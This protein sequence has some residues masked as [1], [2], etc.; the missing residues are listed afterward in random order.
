MI[1]KTLWIVNTESSDSYC[2]AMSDN[3]IHTHNLGYPRIGEQRELKKA[4]EA[5]W[6]GKLSQEELEATGRRLRR[7]NWAKQ[8]AAG[9][10]LIPC[11]DFSFYDQMLDFSCLI[12]N[13]PPRFGWQ[14]ED[15]GLDTLFLMAR[16]SRGEGH[17]GCAHGCGGHEAAFACE[18]TKWFD[19]N[20]HYIVPEFRADTQF[21]LVGSKV[22]R[23][24]AELKALGL[25]AKPVL[26]GPVT[27][28]SLG[29]VQDSQNPDFDRWS[30]LDG[31][32]SV[33]EKILQRLAE[34]G[35]E[36]VQIDEPIFALDLSPQQRDAVVDSW[37][38]LAA[39]APGLKI[40]VAS[41]F[42][43]LRENLPLFLS[44]P[45]H[46]FHV[47]CV[48]APAE[49]DEVLEHL[50][51]DKIL[52]LG[53]V[54]GRNIW[55]N[56][57][58][59]SLKLLTTAKAKLGTQRLWVAPSCSLL[60][61]PVTLASEHTLDAQIENWL[62]FADQ[63]L[64]EVVTLSALLRNVSRS[65][66]LEANQDAILS[67]AS[68]RRTHNPEVRARLALVT[69]QDARRHSPFPQR[70][71]LQQ[72]RLALPEFPT[73]TI[74]SF[75]QTAEVRSMRA[76]WKKG[77][78]TAAEYEAYLENETR[79]CVAFQDAI[80]LDMPV[81][82]E[83]ERNDMVEYFGEQLDGF[84]FTANGWV[85]SYGTRC[86]K[87]PVIYGDVSRPAPMTVRWSKFAQ[88]LTSR[89][90]KGMLTGPVTILQWSF[91]RDDQPRSETTRQIALAIRDEVV[92]LEAAGI[93]AIQIDEPAIRE[94]LPLRRF[95]WAHY[96]DW[97]VTAFRLSASGVRDDTQIHT[98][99]CYS[100]F[101]DIIAAI[102]DMDADVITIET[103]RSNMELLGAF[104]DFQYPNEI[105]P[106]VYDIHSP[107][108]PSVSEMENLMRKAEAVIPRRNLWVNP[109]CG[110]K[111]RGWTEVKTS[112]IHM[113]Q[114][115]KNLR[116]PQLQ[117]AV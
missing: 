106:G 4:T 70:Q 28:L 61:S 92:D 37:R 9:I 83:F 116:A 75:P 29:K 109:D 79:A 114:T 117:P 63:K 73:T 84:L 10:D 95:D 77:D 94:G 104:V 1:N 112:L 67:R 87:P 8:S 76:K 64:T 22:F 108:V 100:E 42:G 33:Y 20:Y 102:A 26:P 78:L 91:V 69:D 113:V 110:L 43:A 51:Q 46:A 98:H 17:E 59:K 105:G 21:Q 44:L 30:L 74:G 90:M 2:V 52:S 24:F 5:F 18:M 45:A 35:A 96:L 34:Q 111:T 115:A 82:G 60:H 36:W 88:S 103:S 97:A 25:R 56:D 12:G 16:G 50:P 54:D 19:T 57:F 3:I 99:M 65:G 27:Y 11:N 13:V 48:R 6:H 66:V 31:L 80:G 14:G 107:R 55:K 53:V 23:E 93:A 72:A 85:Q 40:I 101:N 41:Y 58:T 86:V 32:V 62:A 15:I 7:D 71:A 81:H 39:A 89:P 49:L 47:D 38:R 68:S